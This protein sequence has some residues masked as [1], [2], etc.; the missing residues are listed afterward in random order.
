MPWLWWKD[1]CHFTGQAV[2]TLTRNTSSLTYARRRKWIIG[3]EGLCGSIWLSGT[4]GPQKYKAWVNIRVRGIHPNVIRIQWGGSQLYFCSDSGISAV[5][6]FGGWGKPKEGPAAKVSYCDQLR[7]PM[8]T[9]HRLLQQKVFNDP[10]RY[11]DFGIF[12]MNTEKIE[13]LSTFPEIL[14]DSTHVGL[15]WLE[16]QQ[17]PIFIHCNFQLQHNPSSFSACSFILCLCC[18]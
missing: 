3:S 10:E 17:V 13:Q 11:W 15:M 12:T 6:W 8:F 16:D 5:V 7:D 1:L 14:E 4:S 2:N 18:L 9:W